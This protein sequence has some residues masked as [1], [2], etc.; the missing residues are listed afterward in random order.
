MKFISFFQEIMKNLLLFIFI[1]KKELNLILKFHNVKIYKL[2]N[3]P[4]LKI[5]LIFNNKIR[6]HL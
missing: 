6:L 2:I 4:V 5:N 3:Y 1:I